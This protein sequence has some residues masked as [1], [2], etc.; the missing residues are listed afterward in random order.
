MS[1]TISY[2][3]YSATITYSNEDNALIGKVI[4][5]RD[6]IVFEGQSLDEIQEAFEESIDIYL[7]HCKEKGIQPSKPYSGKFPLRISPELHEK[8]HIAAEGSGKSLNQWM[9]DNSIMALEAESIAKAAWSKSKGKP[10]SISVSPTSSE[11]K[12]NTEI[13]IQ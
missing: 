4:N 2:Q 9:I 11:K 13:T 7:E 8:F 12:R 6:V 5:I 3:G 1:N 10:F